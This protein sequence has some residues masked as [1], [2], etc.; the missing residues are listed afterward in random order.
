MRK[1]VS[2]SK[3]KSC[4]M[5]YKVKKRAAE[6]RR[7]VKKEAKKAKQNHIV[8]REGAKVT[9]IP[10]SFPLKKDMIQQRYFNTQ[11]V[12]KKPSNTENNLNS[13]ITN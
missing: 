8:H 2:K 10:N 4:A 5:K 1:Q 7:K 3:R 9:K 13:N 12:D 6:H 11:T